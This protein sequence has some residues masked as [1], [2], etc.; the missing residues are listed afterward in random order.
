MMYTMTCAMAA[1]TW[2]LACG[3]VD[4]DAKQTPASGSATGSG[5]G[6]GDTSTTGST[7]AT[8]GSNSGGGAVGGGDGG[9][10]TTQLPT[11][12]EGFGAVTEGHDSCPN[13]PE[14]VRVTTLQDGGTGSLREALSAGCRRVVF[15]VAGTIVLTADLN[16][17]YSYVTVDGAT[18]PAPGITIEQ[19][20][21]FG[22][23][24]EARNSI[25]PVSDIIITYLR[26]DGLAQI[27]L[28]EGDIWGMD[29]EAQRVSRIVLDHI[30][31]I[32]ATDGVF[33]VWADVTDVTLSYNLVLDTITALHLSTGDI[34]VSRERFSVHHNVFAR[35]NERQI[36]IRHN[37]QLIDYVN[38]VIYGWGWVEAGAAGLDINYD[39]GEINPS[40]NVINNLF[41]HVASTNGNPGDAVR[42]DRGP[43]EGAVFFSGNIVPSGELDNV[44]SGA[45]LN[46]PS[47]AQVS[48]VPASEL[49]TALVP[50]VGTHYPTSEEQALLQQIAADI[51]Q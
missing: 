16:I 13:T 25:G 35:N 30:T 39:A 23:T 37:N 51:S 32:A 49:A 33:D 31:G 2:L 44:S 14:E 48:R 50:V 45:E 40:L 11:E 21:A 9:G 10:G 34:T 20:G 18:A 42:F 4:N 26:M 15:D 47:E 8:G 7:S 28:N 27:H 1:A 5:A 46:I 3:G 22:T 12:F 43:D 24:I 29:G 38:N 41:H 19:P 36:R 17:P 6:G